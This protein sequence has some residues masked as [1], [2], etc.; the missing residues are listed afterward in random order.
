MQS[1]GD[2]VPNFIFV[3][4][5]FLNV[6]AISWQLRGLRGIYGIMY[7]AFT[8]STLPLLKDTTYNCHVHH[9]IAK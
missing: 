5:P 1:H 9:I 7:V 3:R 6:L 8:A 2:N 4:G